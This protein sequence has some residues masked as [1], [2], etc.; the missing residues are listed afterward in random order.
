MHVIAIIQARMGSKRFPG[1]SMYPF[2]DTPSLLHLL[3]SVQQAIPKKCIYL[4]TSRNKENDA[5][6]AFAQQNDFKVYRGDE[7]NVASRFYEILQKE[8]CDYFIRLNGDS[9]LM[10]YRIIQQALEHI[11]KN[12]DLVSTVPGRKFPSGMNVEMLKAST[13]LSHYPNFSCVDHFEHVTKYF[14]EHEEMF[15][16]IVLSCT[17]DNESRF[18]FCFD[19]EEDRIRIFN[20]FAQL[21]QPH[22]HYTLEEKCAM[23]LQAMKNSKSQM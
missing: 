21:Q 16:K 3:N 9:P 15:T 2:L 13:F 18:N 11:D 4:A 20:I 17:V 6:E 8:T 19:T 7:Q 1:K 12:V 22:Y 5:I 10:D 14:Y 23:Y